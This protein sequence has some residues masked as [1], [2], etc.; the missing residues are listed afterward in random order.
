MKPSPNCLLILASLFFCLYST[1]QHKKPSAGKEPSWVTINQY[2]PAAFK[3]EHEAEDGYA[4][5]I[6]ERQVSLEHESF[7]VRT[8]NKILTETGIQ[9]CSEISVNFDPTYQQLIFHSIKIHRGNAIIDQLNL[10]KIKIIQQEKEL[11]NFLYNG[12]LTAILFLEDV[13]KGDLIDYSYTLKGANPVFKGKFSTIFETDFTVPLGNIYYKLIV[14]ASRTVTIKNRGTSLVPVKQILPH[15]TVYEWKL[16][17]VKPV[18]VQDNLP[19]WYDPYSIVMVSEYQSWKEVN[20]WAMKLFP[21]ITAPS[22]ALKKKINDI[23]SKYSSREEQIAAAL[24]FVQDDIRYMGMELGQNSHKPAH[25][26]KIMAQRFGDCKDKSYLLCTILR[27]LD[28]E[29]SPV[30]INTT[31]KK[32]LLERLPAA[33]AFDHVTVRVHINNK[34]YFFD[35]T[36]SLQEAILIIFRFPIINT[37]L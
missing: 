11:S 6:F 28:I 32:L 13:R 10:G 18:P 33:R 26:D 7:Y 25:P 27:S 24:R 31:I 9:N 20:D 37:D 15:K 30:L 12:S 17:N 4:D 16:D 34:Y 8:G 1:A 36:I 3:L 22:P 14:P 5:I 21:A 2:D 29:A 35:P 19:G 23:R